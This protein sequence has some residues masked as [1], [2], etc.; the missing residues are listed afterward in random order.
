MKVLSEILYKVHLKQV[1][2]TTSINV[3]AVQ[4]DSRKVSVNTLFI[5]TKG[6]QVD[7]HAFIDTAIAAGASHGSGIEM[8]VARYGVQHD[9]GIKDAARDD[10]RCVHG[11]CIAN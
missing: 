8:V 10:A 5:A 9:G 11:G 1:I 4:T 2:G 3:D 6:T 7:G